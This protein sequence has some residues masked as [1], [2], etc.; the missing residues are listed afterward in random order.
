M[1][2][3]K[4]IAS[5]GACLGL[6]E[7]MAAETAEKREISKNS[8]PSEVSEYARTVTLHRPTPDSSIEPRQKSMS[9]PEP[10]K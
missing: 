9:S 10:T 5:L 3:R 1:E 7:T 6:S 2:R 8:T 4:V